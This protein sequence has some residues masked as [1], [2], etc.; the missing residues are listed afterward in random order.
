MVL[1][2]VA[3]PLSVAVASNGDAAVKSGLVEKTE[4]RRV[5]IDVTVRGPA[6]AMTELSAEDFEVVVG[7]RVIERFELDSLCDAPPPPLVAVGESTDSGNTPAMAGE[8]PGL[9][10]LFYFDQFHL[11]EEGRRNSLELA[12]SLVR[13]LIV[14]GNRA[15]IASSARDVRTFADWTSDQDV[16]LEALDRLEQDRLQFDEYASGE[17]LRVQRVLN[18]LDAGSDLQSG[19][20]NTI[21]R[22]MGEGARISNLF[23]LADEI[24]Q[25]SGVRG[26]ASSGKSLAR[27]ALEQH[28][29][30][31][32][33]SA[34]ALMD[35]NASTAQEFGEM[36]ARDL[37][38]EEQYHARRGTIRIANVLKRFIGVPAPKAMV[39]FGDTLRANP[40][41]HY[42]RLLPIPESE[43]IF[44]KV[45]T[46]IGSQE[47]EEVIN[48]A[49]SHGV[50]I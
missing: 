21:A 19:A 47:Y 2:T 10:L 41:D 23:V 28:W 26:P 16:L 5:Q 13:E 9:S 35:L 33:A 37:Q 46:A 6:Q 30:S 36:I 50:R 7:R 34:S 4:V 45:F 14:E 49:T 48:E 42:M 24:S 1:L 8:R 17:D 20:A 3:V 12:R 25:A 18:V 27:K 38:R 29:A 43:W 39:Y 15:M 32:T 22:D 40:G 44:P 31:L 11:K